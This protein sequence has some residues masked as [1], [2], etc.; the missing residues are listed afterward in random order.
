MNGKRAVLFLLVF[1]MSLPLHSASGDRVIS[2]AHNGSSWGVLEE[3]NGMYSFL[4]VSGKEMVSPTRLNLTG[5]PCGLVWNGSEWIVETF[6]PDSVVVQTLDGSSLFKLH[7]YDCRSFTYLN[8]SY[9]IPISES[10]MMGDCSLLRVSQNGSVEKTIPCGFIN[11]VK[12]KV[13]DGK[14][15]S[16]NCTGVYFYSSGAFKRFC[17]SK[18]AQRISI[19]ST[20]STCSAPQRVF[21]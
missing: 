10:A 13:R 1:L 7:S 6:V 14:L 2:I 20:S 19:F 8:G 3:K 16:M 11:G 12:V 4:T 5:D 9:H 18:T 15:Y 17:G 21:P